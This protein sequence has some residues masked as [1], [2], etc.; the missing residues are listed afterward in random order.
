MNRA[1]GMRGAVVPSVGRSRSAVSVSCGFRVSRLN[2]NA[3]DLDASYAK[4]PEAMKKKDPD[5]AY[6]IGHGDHNP[7]GSG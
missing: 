4:D 2:S 5:L 6:Y 1:F 3:F 7:D